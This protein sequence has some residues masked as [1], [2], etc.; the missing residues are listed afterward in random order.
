MGLEAIVLKGWE[1]GEKR[2]V[3]LLVSFDEVEVD[4]ILHRLYHLDLLCWSKCG[5]GLHHHPDSCQW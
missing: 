2:D 1:R 3:K 5:N 4:Y